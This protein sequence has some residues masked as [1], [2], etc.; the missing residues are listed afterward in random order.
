MLKRSSRTEKA[1]AQ[2]WVFFR[3]IY[4]AVCGGSKWKGLQI[5]KSIRPIDCK[6]PW[7]ILDH[8]NDR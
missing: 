1:I 5:R 7:R 4:D 3:I 2:Q 6:S 8:R